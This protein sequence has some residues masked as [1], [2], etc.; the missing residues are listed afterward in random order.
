MRDS[1]KLILRE[2]FHYSLADFSTA[3]ISSGEEKRPS[4]WSLLRCGHEHSGSSKCLLWC[5]ICCWVRKSVTCLNHNRRM[6]KNSYHCMVKIYFSTFR[7]ISI[8]TS[9]EMISMARALTWY[10]VGVERAISKHLVGVQGFIGSSTLGLSP[11]QEKCEASYRIANAGKWTDDKINHSNNGIFQPTSHVWI[12][13][14][15]TFC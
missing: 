14:F 3:S 11:S 4:D 2:F 13:I 6:M 9:A 8:D 5:R 7:K 15:A 12:F 10:E 1:A